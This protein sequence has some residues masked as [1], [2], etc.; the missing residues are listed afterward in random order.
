MGW[1][2]DRLV[3]IY[4]LLQAKFT[5]VLLIQFKCV[6][7]LIEAYETLHAEGA[8][9]QDGLDYYSTTFFPT[10]KREV[11]GFRD[12]VESLAVN[13]TPLPTG[14]MLPYKIP[15]EVEG[16]FA[17]LDMFTA[18]A[19]GGKLTNGG[20]QGGRQLPDAPAVAGCFGRVVI[21][22]TRW[23]RRTPG[24][25][26]A[27]RVTITTNSGSKVSVKGTLE[28]RAVKY[29]PYKNDKGVELH[30]GYQ[31]QV[32]NEPRDMDKVL[33]AHFTPS[34][35]LP[36]DIAASGSEPRLL[37]LALE[38]GGGEVLAQTK[39]YVLPV[40]VGE[41]QPVSVPYGTFTMSFTGGAGVR[42]R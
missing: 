42:G 7:L 41:S 4:D 13:I 8:S 27:A 39:A 29:T 38:T 19:L 20:A 37:D 36:A 14:S 17:G 28:V 18:Q 12:M 25:T 9:E 2:N 23:I 10:L 5:R 30:K 1:D 3:K 40:K 24:A 16:M 22:A 26:E 35:V 32:G 34:E 15:Q 31:I 6:R 33:V 21:P 11:E